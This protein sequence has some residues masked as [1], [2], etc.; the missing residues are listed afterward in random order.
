MS[1]STR[2]SPFIQRPASPDASKRQALSLQYKVNTLQ[3]E[4]E[5]EKLSFQREYALLDKKYRSTLDGLDKALNDT[6]YLYDT[7]EELEKELEKVKEELSQIKRESET[8]NLELKQQIL[9]KDKELDDLQATSQS[10][11][12]LY[13]NRYHNSQV[14]VEGSKTLLKRYESEIEKQNSEIKRLQKSVAQKDDEVASLKASRVVMAHHNYSTEELKELTTLNKLLQDQMSFSKDLERTNLAQGN[15]LKKLRA[16][17]ESQQFLKAEND[18]LRRKLEQMEPLQTQIQDIQLENINLQSNLA[19]WGLYTNDQDGK[20]KLGPEEIVREWRVLKQ[21]NLNLVNENSKLQLDLSN[22]KILNDE[23]ALE[24]NQILDLNKNYESSIL[25]L[26]KLNYEIEQ[27]KLLSFEECKLLRQQ[28]EE[29]SSIDENHKT[30]PVT[31]FEGIIDGYKNRTEDLTNELKKLNEAILRDSDAGYPSKR[32]K[33]SDDVALNYSQRLNELQLQNLELNRKYQ[34]ATET[35]TLLQKKI[36]KIQE[37]GEKRIRIL[38]L[39]DSPF[40][41]DQFVKKKRLISLQREN[42]DLLARLNDTHVEMIPRS[43]Y[44]RLKLDLAE[45]EDEVFNSNKKNVRL[46]E[47]FNKKSLEFID[48]VNSLLG[49]KLEFQ[50]DGQIKLISCFKPEK[51]LLADLAHNKLK[52]NLDTEIEGWNE[53]L[54]DLVGEKGQIPCFLATITLKLWEKYQRLP[55]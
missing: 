14:E 50:T 30:E 44:E 43:V 47:I 52:S 33:K 15:E 10:K 12:S 31:S 5:I 4:F 20:T 9:S 53:I 38:Q 25:N 55:C 29:L 22:L 19:S 39:R 8:R 40:L 1:E 45:L 32:R 54:G 34:A 6:K 42:E 18:K 2:S 26:K 7:N 46:R 36:D 37:I 16:T 27:Q 51:Y 49:F 11:L 28:L 35:I 48:A 24:R 23:L 21:E 3:N 41:K 13:E 17:Q